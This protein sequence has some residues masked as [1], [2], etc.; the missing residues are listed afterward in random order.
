MET[1]IPLSE[2]NDFTYSPESLYLHQIYK[3]FDE[4]IYHETPQMT[5]LEYHASLEDGRYSRAKRFIQNLS[6]YSERYNIGGKIDLYC[7]PTKTLTERKTRIKQIHDGHRFQIY[8]Q[9][10]CM[11][12]MGYSVDYLYIYSMSDNK[13]YHIPKPDTAEIKKFGETLKR[14][15]S[16]NPAKEK[17]AADKCELSIYRHLNY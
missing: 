13:R 6:V 11:E 10:F 16:F 3:G 2:I 9:M 12:E 5:G 17:V 1:Y 8:G 14:I 4:S 15:R 7:L